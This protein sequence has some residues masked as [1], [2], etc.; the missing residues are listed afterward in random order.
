MKNI[1][2]DYK[3]LT[4][5]YER[6]YE[7]FKNFSREAPERDSKI[8]VP[9]D[10]RAI[11]DHLKTDEYIIF[12]RLYTHLDKKYGYKND[13]GSLSPFFSMQAGKDRHVIN[14]PLLASVIAGLKEERSKQ[15]TSMYLSIIAI[16]ISFLTLAINGFKTWNETANAPQQQQQDCVKNQLPKPLKPPQK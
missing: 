14:F 4:E 1:P 12:G 7:Q 10:I 11:A 2:S 15:N 3:L 6:Y 16:T 8:Y 5:I 13:D 9:I